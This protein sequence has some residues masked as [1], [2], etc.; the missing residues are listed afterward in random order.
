MSGNKADTHLQPASVQD[1]GVRVPSKAGGD[2]ALKG[3]TDPAG[4]ENM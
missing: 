3:V 4:R 2:P 1:S